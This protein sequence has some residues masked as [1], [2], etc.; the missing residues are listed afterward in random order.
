MNSTHRLDKTVWQ[1]IVEQGQTD[2]SS[3]GID[4]YLQQVWERCCRQQDY[5]TWIPPHRAKG[6]TFDN[7]L[8]NKKQLLNIAIPTI[9]DLAEHMEYTPCSFILTDETGCTLYINNHPHI[10]EQMHNLGILDGAYWHE[11]IIGNNAISSALHLA[12]VSTSIEYEHFKQVLHD[13]AIFAAPLFDNTGN[14]QGCFALVFLVNDAYPC[15]NALVHSATHDIASQL[16]VEHLLSESNQYLSEMHTL[17]DSVDEGV[18]SWLPNGHINYFNHTCRDML[19]LSV[20]DLGKKMN[21]LFKIPARLAR[22]IK[23]CKDV[24]NLDVVVE[25]KGKLISLSISLKVVKNE[26][27]HI[28]SYIILFSQPQQNE[29]TVHRKGLKNNTQYTFD[30]I[31][32]QSSIMHDTVYHAQ[33]AAK[34]HGAIFIQ[35]RE[36]CGRNL[37]AQAVHNA[38]NRHKKPFISINCNAIPQ[39]HMIEEFLIS[40]QGDTVSKFELANGGTLYLEHIENLIPE[41][42]AALLQLIKTGL[43]NRMNGKITSLDIRIIATSNVDLEQE[44]AEK[45]FSKQL[46]LE[47]N[48][49]TIKLPKLRKHVE[50]IPPF[51]AR[52]LARLSSQQQKTFTISEAALNLL[53]QYR[54]PG[55]IR[56]LEN[57]IERTATVAQSESIEVSDLPDHIR[58]L[59]DGY[60]SQVSISS[61]NLFELERKA[62]IRS[63]TQFS[64][65]I[66]DMCQDLQISRTTLWRKIKTYE[67]DI[68]EY[69]K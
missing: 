30:D 49:F 33:H 51:V 32:A 41:V 10:Q 23:K 25:C 19:G 39:E 9:E 27:H 67:L 44:V 28:N 60:S 22:A 53:M 17:L 42:Q 38:S 50:D 34:G 1:G 15:A 14:I 45:H 7:I 47:L 52:E 16:Q 13:F 11:N 62:I 69:K 46:L 55:D 8:K 26:F 56:E 21:T 64:G 43:F 31:I 35:G 2:T 3:Y 24:N 48:T 58:L 18:I 6:V 68:A 57:V 4:P 20:R 36:G 59:K 63:A 61:N 5:A 66:T 54:W 29:E 40:S 12:N 65:K 37:F